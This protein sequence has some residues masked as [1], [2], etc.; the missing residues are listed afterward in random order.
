MSLELK[1]QLDDTVYHFGSEVNL[2]VWKGILTLFTSHCKHELTFN[3]A[4]NRLVYQGLENKHDLRYDFPAF[5]R[6]KKDDNQ[7]KF[8]AGKKKLEIDFAAIFIKE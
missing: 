2:K 1:W 4:D 5:G 8:R 7:Y 3:A 6:V